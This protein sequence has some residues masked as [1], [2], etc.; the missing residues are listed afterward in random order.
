VR[1]GVRAIGRRSLDLSGESW[2]AP[3]SVDPGLIAVSTL[4][5]TGTV[6]AWLSL[7]RILFPSGLFSRG[8][9]RIPKRLQVQEVAYADVTGDP[10][11]HLDF[12]SDKLARLGFV[13]ADHPFRIPILQSIGYEVLLVPFANAEERAIFLMGIEARSFARV[14][15]LMLHIV[16]PMSNEKTCRVE[17]TTLGALQSIRGPAQVDLRVVIDAESVEEFWSRH[18]RALTSYERAERQSVSIG[19]WK[20]LISAAY[21]A[22]VEAAVRAQRLRLSKDGLTYRVRAPS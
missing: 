16:T 9:G 10:R 1:K 7:E 8:A 6:L 14:P 12:L 19:T 2:K 20:P 5:A 17:T 4:V 18:R 15:D 3:H 22:W 13:R 21:E 11:K